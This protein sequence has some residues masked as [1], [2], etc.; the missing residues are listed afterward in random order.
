MRDR[1]VGVRIDGDAVG[2]AAGEDRRGVWWGAGVRESTVGPT[3]SEWQRSFSELQ[4][5]LFV[6]KIG[7]V[8]KWRL[9]KNIIKRICPREV[10]LKDANVTVKY[11]SVPKLLESSWLE[12]LRY[13]RP[14]RSR[15]QIPVGTN[16]RLWVKKPPRCARRKAWPSRAWARVRRFYLPG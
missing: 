4:V 5:G 8:T 15:V 11:H 10:P 14:T 2:R 3:G 16:F 9:P 12:E 13:G 7:C 6:E 1:G